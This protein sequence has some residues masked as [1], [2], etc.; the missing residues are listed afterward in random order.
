VRRGRA[1]RAR[2][3]QW[4]GIPTGI[5]I[6][7]T[8]TLAKLANHVSKDAERKPGSYPSDMAR[9]CNLA[10]LPLSDFDA[11]LQA[12]P[13]QEIWGV[14][15][16]IGRQLRDGGIATALD[17]AR[18][19]AGTVRRRW[20]VV[21]ERTVREL[22]GQACI[23][24]DD[25]PAPKQQIACTRSFGHPVTTRHELVAAV[26]SFASRVA[27]KLRKQ[28][29]VAGQVLVFI[30]TSPFRRNEPQYS[31]SIT[32]PLRSPCAD[33]AVIS[34]AAC[35]GL[36]A[37]FKDGINYARAGVMLLD[38]S[39]V[40]TEQLELA[41]DEGQRPDARVASAMDR[42]NDRFGRGTL[43]LAGAGTQAAKQAWTM[44]Q[45]RRTPAYTTSWSDMPVARA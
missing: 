15:P 38:L 1:I 11:I 39:D 30:H 14:G 19:D 35:A 12:T 21:L 9:V 24:L 2:I 6:G 7:L 22:Q 37:I 10:A 40:K 18:M 17:L 28:G 16:R 36:Q 32:V 45:E 31:R 42:I 4:I 33:S 43:H 44:K 8:K 23:Q 34:Q 25:G 29:G 3:L 20:S 27:E 41:L 5:G 13:V 26:T